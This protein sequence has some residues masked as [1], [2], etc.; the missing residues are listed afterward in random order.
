MD[1]L[2]IQSVKHL[3]LDNVVLEHNPSINMITKELLYSDDED[4]V[5][6]KEEKYEKE[7]GKENVNKIKEYFD[8]TAE[9]TLECLMNKTSYLRYIKDQQIKEN[10]VKT[11][12]K[13]RKFYKKRINDLTKQL[14]HSEPSPSI[15][16]TKAFDNYINMSINYFKTL[17]KTDILQE[18]YANII[19]TELKNSTN[20]TSF[21]TANNS[22]MRFVKMYEPNSL[23][24][25]I[26]RTITKLPEPDP[27]L[28]KQ[29]N[30][31]LKDPILRNKG[32]CKKNNISNK[33]EDPTKK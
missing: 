18:D 31:N 26:K 13:D 19:A 14:M 29:K 2:N 27:V 30:I 33:Y 3:D 25:I 21:D 9:I 22:I 16:I 7:E 6:E 24:K 8:P 10:I 5:E 4:E 15:E 20:L 28:P 12:L 32:I 17:D 23:E 11:N 1:Q